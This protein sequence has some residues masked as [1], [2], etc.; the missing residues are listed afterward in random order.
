MPR[1]L[2]VLHE[3]R[4]RIESA[5][6]PQITEYCDSPIVDN[7]RKFKRLIEIPNIVQVMKLKAA[8]LVESLSSVNFW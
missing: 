6:N 5:W 7:V 2:V 3:P 1:V 8:R 4:W